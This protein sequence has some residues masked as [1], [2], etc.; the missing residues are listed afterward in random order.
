MSRRE[1]VCVHGPLALLAI[2]RLEELR[3]LAASALS[4]DETPG[5]RKP[6]KRAKARKR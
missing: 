6:K 1:W 5:K 2:L 3:T 4:Q